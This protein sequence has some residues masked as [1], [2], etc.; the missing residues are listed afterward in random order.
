MREFAVCGVDVL[1]LH[2]WLKARG[3]APFKSKVP[4]WALDGT[5]SSSE[6]LAEA[7]DQVTRAVGSVARRPAAVRKRK[8]SAASASV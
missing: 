2:A 8:A 7:F 1:A 6:P 4:P 5:M 3:A